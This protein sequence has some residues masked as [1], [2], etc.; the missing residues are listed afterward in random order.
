MAKIDW[1]EKRLENWARWRLKRSAN[2]LGFPKQNV[3]A[4]FW[5]PP[6]NR[7]AVAILPVDENEAWTLE[8][9]IGALPL[10]LKQTVEQRYLTTGSVTDD[11]NALGCGV[12]TVHARIEDAHR[13]LAEA[14]NVRRGGVVARGILET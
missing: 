4:R 13:R 12:S 6:R 14:L 9:C 8:Q 3:L 10:V 11:A 2:A 5:S 1:I 7:E